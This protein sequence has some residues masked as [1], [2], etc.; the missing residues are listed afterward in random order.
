MEGLLYNVDVVLVVVYMYFQTVCKNI[1]ITILKRCFY[2]IIQF[3]R[4]KGC[5]S[6]H[7]KRFV[8]VGVW[9]VAAVHPPPPHPTQK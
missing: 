4:A 6:A 5:D 3:A 1:A 7:N 2:G 9:A 8:G